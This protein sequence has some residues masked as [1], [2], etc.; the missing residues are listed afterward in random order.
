MQ[1]PGVGGGIQIMT[2][3]V[4]TELFGISLEVATGAAVLLWIIAFVVIVPF[5]LVLAVHEGLSWKRLRRIEQEA[6]W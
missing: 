5:G 4:L 3:L 6:G 2:V 1:I